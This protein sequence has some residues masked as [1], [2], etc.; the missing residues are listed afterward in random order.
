MLFSQEPIKMKYA[1][2]MDLTTNQ[3]NSSSP[4]RCI[5]IYLCGKMNRGRARGQLVEVRTRR[6]QQPPPVPPAPHRSTHPPTAWSAPPHAGAQTL[7]S[8][9]VPPVLASVAFGFDLREVCKGAPNEEPE[10]REEKKKRE[11]LFQRATRFRRSTS[12]PGGRSRKD[13]VSPGPVNL[14]AM[15]SISECNSTKCLL[16]SDFEGSGYNLVNETPAS[17]SQTH[18]NTG[19]NDVL[20]S[21]PLQDHPSGPNSRL[22][23]KKSC[24]A[25]CQTS[26]WY[27][28][29]L[30]MITVLYNYF[31][32]W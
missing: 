17:N 13:E 23:R 8:L 14:L 32:Y 22:R 12:P 26:K 30:G 15:S 27:V 18:Q 16:Q 19:T 10:L 20:P 24:P 11:G 7:S 5:L 9:A 21:V 6:T 2:L 31:L 1:L 25:V 28:I 3:S 29:I 4:T